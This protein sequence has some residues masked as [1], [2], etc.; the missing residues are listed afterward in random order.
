MTSVDVQT[1]NGVTVVS[2]AGHANYSNDHND[3]VCAA[4]STITQSLLQTIKYYEELGKCKVIS[5][6]VKEDIGAVLFSF[7]SMDESVTDALMNMA[8]IGYL[9]LEKAYPKNICVNV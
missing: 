6:Q 2:V 7:K 3:I 9:M 5:E 4:I 8:K 1:I